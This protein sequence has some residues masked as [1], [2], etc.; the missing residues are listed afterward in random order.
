MSRGGFREGSGRK[1]GESTVVVRVPAALEVDIKRMISNYKL[2][3]AQYLNM[4][5]MSPEEY[6]KS[7]PK[8]K[9]AFGIERKVGKKKKKRK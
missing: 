7:I 2:N 3:P 9:S 6:F 8:L 5:R 1:K 4:I